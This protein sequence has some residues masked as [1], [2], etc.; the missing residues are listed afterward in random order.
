[1]IF[2]LDL[3]QEDEIVKISNHKYFLQS[4]LMA[5]KEFNK[6]CP[7]IGGII[8]R[9]HIGRNTK[10]HNVNKLKYKDNQL[11]VDLEIFNKDIDQ[12]KII[13][14]PIISTPLRLNNGVE[15]ERILDIINIMIEI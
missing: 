3:K 10:T 4:L 9:D 8:D 1:M 14:K 12:S 15:I 11:I 13:I 5:I 6:K 2:K 7:K